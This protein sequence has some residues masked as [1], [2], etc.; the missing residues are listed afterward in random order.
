MF[1][2]K[3][4][5]ALVLCFALVRVDAA[6]IPEPVVDWVESNVA[7]IFAGR[8]YG[9]GFFIAPDL[10]IT[11]C[12]VTMPWST[13]YVSPEGDDTRYPAIV[14]VCDE[15]KD[16]ALLRLYKG[17]PDSMATTIGTE[18][19]RVGE[20]TYGSGYPVGLPLVIWAGHYQRR[21]LL[22]E[23]SVIDTNHAI[24]GDSG[25]PLL[26]YKDGKVQVVGVRVAGLRAGPDQVMFPNV[27]FVVPLDQ[28]QEFLDENN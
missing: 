7:K 21:S 15:E 4:I 18:I 3:A 17:I 13:V 24:P 5:I 26:I 8:G 12:H 9:S 2:R 23:T 6:S 19:P 16:L 1:I 22:D 10:L 28:L 27:A 11:A 14:E 25:S 20:Q